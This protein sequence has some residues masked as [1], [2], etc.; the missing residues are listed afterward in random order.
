MPN[1]NRPKDRSYIFRALSLL[2]SVFS[3]CETR[4]FCLSSS[5]LTLLSPRGGAQCS[6]APV[7]WARECRK[8]TEICHTVPPLFCPRGAKEILLIVVLWEDEKTQ[9]KRKVIIRDPNRV[10]RVLHITFNFYILVTVL[11]PA[12]N[13]EA[14]YG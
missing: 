4:L 8:P 14:F 3:T 5:I 10:Q 13:C 11:Q 2:N 1:C 7:Q 12:Q 6:L 9:K